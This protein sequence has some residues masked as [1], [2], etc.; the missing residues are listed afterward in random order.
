MKQ[1]QRVLGALFALALLF[2]SFLYGRVFLQEGIRLQG[3]FLPLQSKAHSREAMNTY[4]NGNSH[5][6]LQRLSGQDILVE[7]RL[8]EEKWEFLLQE[9]TLEAGVRVYDTGNNLIF[10]TKESA[11]EVPEEDLLL[12][13][14][15]ME[16]SA[17]PPLAVTEEVPSPAFL[18][19]LWKEPPLE[20]RGDLRMLAAALALFVVGTGLATRDRFSA[21]HGWMFRDGALH[22]PGVFSAVER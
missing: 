1:E 21:A 2:A 8:G 11:L 19:A 16:A 5:I 22:L 6:L 20:R 10:Q 12:S 3:Q 9:P 4:A 7:V 15:V 17:P 14:G 18:V 13:M